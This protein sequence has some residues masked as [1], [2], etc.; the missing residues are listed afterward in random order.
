MRR[1]TSFS[2]VGLAAA[3]LLVLT[4]QM[5]M[6]QEA[7]V[8]IDV[9]VERPGVDPFQE[10]WHDAPERD[11]YIK[12]GFIGGELLI[13]DDFDAAFN[14]AEIGVGLGQPLRYTMDFH[15]GDL[16]NEPLGAS[17]FFFRALPVGLLFEGLIVRDEGAN[18]DFGFNVGARGG[19]TLLFTDSDV[20]SW[21]WWTV[22]GYLGLHLYIDRVMLY[23]NGG[24]A[25][26][27]A[28]YVLD[29]GDAPVAPFDGQPNDADMWTIA[30][31]LGITFG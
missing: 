30:F 27:F 6:A 17:D 29:T 22:E 26:N 3:A 13:K 25:F 18:L 28:G 7:D 21:G 19:A 2:F 31:G 12:A 15:L 16:S 9:P 23:V 20:D 24:Y 11:Y 4:P 14:A 1:F 10:V 5:A 8:E